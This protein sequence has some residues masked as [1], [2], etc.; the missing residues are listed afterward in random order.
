V[1][2]ALQD[3]LLNSSTKGSRFVQLSLSAAYSSNI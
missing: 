1:T 3:S 2:Q